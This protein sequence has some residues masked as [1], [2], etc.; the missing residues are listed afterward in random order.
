MQ[1]FF[2]VMAVTGTYF[3]EGYFGVILEQLEFTFLNSESL[4]AVAQRMVRKIESF[5]DE[6]GCFFDDTLF[7]SSGPCTKEKVDGI[8]VLDCSESVKISVIGNAGF[9]LPTTK[10]LTKHV[11]AEVNRKRREALKKRQ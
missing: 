3:S 2:V 11:F 9:D 7:S 10:Q 5:N 1:Q 6:E 8:P 4:T